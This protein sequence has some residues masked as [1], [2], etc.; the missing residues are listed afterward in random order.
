MLCRGLKAS[1]QRTLAPDQKQKIGQWPNVDS[2]GSRP[3][4]PKKEQSKTCWSAQVFLTN[5]SPQ[6]AFS[7][8][9]GQVVFFCKKRAK[10]SPPS[11]PC[12]RKF[13]GQCSGQP[14]IYEKMEIHLSEFS[15]Q[16]SPEK[17]AEAGHVFFLSGIKIAYSK[18]PP[19][20][21]KWRG[22]Y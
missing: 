12:H 16:L 3:I 13:F 6:N 10:K 4:F 18:E 1:E 22:K 8:R 17:P 5:P 19:Q 7:D 14:P 9:K 20:P 2:F 11:S 21:K 15:L